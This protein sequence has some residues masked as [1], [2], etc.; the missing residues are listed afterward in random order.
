MSSPF[1]LRYEDLFPPI[2]CI[3]AVVTQYLIKI[4][5]NQRLDDED[6]VETE[7][8]RF[9]AFSVPESRIGGA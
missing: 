9:A 6:L 4:L 1:P 8:V 2:Y 7:A 3:V 5:C